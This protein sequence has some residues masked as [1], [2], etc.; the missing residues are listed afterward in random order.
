MSESI[1]EAFQGISHE[2]P[3]HYRNI[4]CR[5]ILSTSEI[6]ESKFRVTEFYHRDDMSVTE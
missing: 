2:L 5:F 6:R 4:S 3:R 1:S